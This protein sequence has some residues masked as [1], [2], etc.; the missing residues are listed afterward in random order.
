MFSSL[1]LFVPFQSTREQKIKQ[2]RTKS[3]I[4]NFLAEGQRIRDL[5]AKFR[6]MSA[7]ADPC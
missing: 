2:T 6:G 5:N 4:P 7:L 1:H 3:S